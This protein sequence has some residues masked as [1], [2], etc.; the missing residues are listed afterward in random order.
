MV[1]GEDALGSVAPRLIRAGIPSVLAMT[2]SVLVATT[3]ALCGHFYR[4]LAGGEAIGAAL[5]AARTQLLRTPKRGER[6]R[7]AER[8]RWNLQDWFVPALYQAGA[9]A[10]AV[11]RR[12]AGAAGRAAAQ[13]AASRRNPG[14]YGRRRELFDIE[15]WFVGGTRRIVLSG[16]GGQGKTALATEAG[17]WLLRTGLF[18][19]VCFVSYAGFQGSDPVQLAVSTLATVLGI[20]LIDAEAAGAA[21]ALASRR[22]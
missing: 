4:E 14:F 9:D 15:R 2:Q 19:R 5:D 6:Q 18:E 16:F 1:S 17:R 10:A 7:P 22:C 3:R 20:N 21:L 11:D 12:P 13:S 8:L